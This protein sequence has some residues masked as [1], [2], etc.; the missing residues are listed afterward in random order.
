MRGNRWNNIPGIF[1]VE[2]AVEGNDIINSDGDVLKLSQAAVAELLPLDVADIAI[3]FRSNGYYD[4]GVCS[5]PV[6]KCYPPEGEDERILEFATAGTTRLSVRTAQALF[7]LYE[8]KIME[9]EIDRNAWEPD[10]DDYT[11]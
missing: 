6:E 4:P 7:D 10:H 11:D 2:L 3:H 8:E 5:G 1:T 9:V